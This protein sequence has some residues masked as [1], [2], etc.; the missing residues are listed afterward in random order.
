MRTRH[1]E[2]EIMD[3]PLLDPKEHQRALDGLARLNAASGSVWALWHPIRRLAKSLGRKD[4]RV[5]DIAT[6]SADNPIALWELAQRAGY[7][8]Q[9]DG[10]DV[11]DVAVKAARNRAA[12]LNSPCEFFLLDALRD[13]LPEGYDVVMCS[14]FTHHL[15]RDDA[16]QLLGKMK[17]A[18]KHM[19]IVN[20]LVRSYPSLFMVTL[21]T[22][23]LSRSKVVH[24]DGPA[25]V[26]SSFTP[27]EMMSLAV[28][29]GLEGA[30]IQQHFPCRMMLV[31]D[32][33]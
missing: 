26:R 14:L 3:D 4:L 31:W 29:A 17:N 33:P 19:V 25:S 16:I 13:P 11:S 12:R 7:D 2:P 21:A 15:E 5:L 9:V 1:R 8:I 30:R 6:G 20:D 24:F 32:R 18:A 28:E 22:Q 27:L 23:V 10:C